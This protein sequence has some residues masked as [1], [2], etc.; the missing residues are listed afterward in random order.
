MADRFA[1]NFPR[2]DSV[3]IIAPAE[4]RPQL[5][6]LRRKPDFF[7]LP[8]QGIAVKIALTLGCSSAGRASRSQCEGREFDPPQLHQHPMKARSC[9]A[10]GFST[11]AFQILRIVWPR[12]REP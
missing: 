6:D 1:W 3:R 11:Q 5:P 4:Y 2:G 9:R 8:E 12:W 10:F 7:A